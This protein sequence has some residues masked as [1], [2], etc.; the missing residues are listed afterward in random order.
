MAPEPLRTSGQGS[1]RRIPLIKPFINDDVIERV[2]AVLK[3]GYLT[4]GPVTKE[5]ERRVR[6]YVG[7]R[8]AIAFTS[9]TT[10]MESVLRGWAIGPGDEVILPDYTY[11]ATASVVEIVGATPVLVDIDRATGN[12]NFDAVAQAVTPRTK[13]ILPVSL[14]G[15][16]L[17][18]DRLRH[19]QKHGMKILEDAACSIGAEY[20]GRKVGSIADA[21]VFS[22]HPRKF[23]TTGE[24]GMVTT[25]D[26]KLATFLTSYKH[27]G[28][29][30]TPTDDGFTVDSMRFVRAGTN[31]K[32]SNLLA[33][34]GLA[35]L[36]VIDKLLARRRELCTRYKTLLKDEKRVSFFTETKDGLHSW[37]SFCLLVE[38]R[39]AIIRQLRKKGIETQIGSFA[40]HKQPAFAA[41]P[42]DG[43]EDSVF[44]DERCLTLPLYDE[45][46]AAE[47][48]EVVRE[49]QQV[50]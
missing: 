27:F 20:K 29:E 32:L 33:A 13:A 23:I 9:N 6:D 22:F 8:F 39:D 50:L 28:M 11:P 48:E 10:G 7:A 16:P 40:L 49:L 26:E 24:G 43:L 17:D 34:I 5:F 37:Q 3:T 46:E 18:Y 44:V 31:Y 47:Q 45:M 38:N 41:L 2:T 25:N 42:H 35:Q 36:D 15:N 1:P 30:A 14:F 19:F 4:E 12:I 21:S